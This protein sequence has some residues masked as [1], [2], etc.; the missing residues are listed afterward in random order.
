MVER[1]ELIR[2]KRK[3]EFRRFLAW[4]FWKFERRDSYRRPKGN[5]NKMRVE[6][7]GYPPRAKVGYRTRR[8][9]RGLHPSGLSPVTVSSKE[10]LERLK[11]EEHI[12]YIS[13]SV[14]LRKKLEIAKAAQEKGLRVAGW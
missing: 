6:V 1:R 7:K 2:R 13:S 9:I 12:V 5:D 14:G 10:E 3:P 8:E 4:E 11:P